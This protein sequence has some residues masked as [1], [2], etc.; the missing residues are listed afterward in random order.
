MPTRRNEPLLLFESWD[1]QSHEIAPRNRLFSL[2]PIGVG[3]M[4][5]ESF[6][7]YIAR[8]AKAHSVTAGALFTYELAPRSNKSYLL[9]EN[10]RGQGVLSTT[11]YPATPALNGMGSTAID[12]VRIVEELNGRRD[13]RFLTMLKWTDVLTEKLFSRAVRAWC[14]EC[15]EEQKA[16]CADRYE[17]LLWIQ[18]IVKVCPLHK[19]RL[20]T[21][22]PN[23]GRNMRPLGDRSLPGF[24]SRC[25][26]WLAS[27]EGQDKEPTDMS[28]EEMN[29]EVWVAKQVGQLIAAAPNLSSEPTKQM[30]LESLFTCIAL[31]SGGNGRGFARHFGLNTI[32]VAS[33]R[34]SVFLPQTDLLLKICSQME[35]SLFDF[36]VTKA[37]LSNNE[38][39]D[40]AERIRAHAAR[41]YAR[42]EPKNVKRA[43]LA[44]LKEK[45]PRSL[46]DIAQGLGYVSAAGIRK[47]FPDICQKLQARR[48]L[49]PSLKTP[50]LRLEVRDDKALRRLL[51]EALNQE[52]PPSLYVLA[53][54]LGYKSSHPLL[55]RFRELCDSII[56]RRAEWKRKR[57]ESIKR[58]LE[59]ALTENPAPSLTNLARRLGYE[60]GTTIGVYFPRLCAKI[61]RRHTKFLSSRREEIRN[62]LGAALS[63]AVPP[64]L[65]E[66]AD[67]IGYS[68]S[69]L[70]VQFP[71][72]CRLLTKRRRGVL[73]R[74]SVSRKKRARRSIKLIAKRLYAEKV[75]PSI[76]QVRAKLPTEI[77]VDTKELS[78]TLREVRREL[79]LP[80]RFR[81]SIS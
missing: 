50:G 45:R 37:Y 66:L 41:K 15:L 67:R 44:A 79:G 40:M 49:L 72:E 21:D 30:V 7:S 6:T 22:C 34:R 80:H 38:W 75:Y 27:L 57:K 61:S 73:K 26:E 56:N 42:R 55:R 39:R 29:Y 76:T 69:Y 16:R 65:R 46:T 53:R 12:W 52:Y 77:S 71:T 17:H 74:L 81:M 35:V 47:L 43:L 13:L 64:T 54:N 78:D 14:S 62:Q 4:R 10:K 23:C 8:Q 60:T 28:Q 18:K 11:F 3:T 24:C 51:F 5:C 19:R 68:W 70:S 1:L 58:A 31:T 48:G 9:R 33:W 59:A 20:E 2:E 25:G 63:E 32:T 36:I